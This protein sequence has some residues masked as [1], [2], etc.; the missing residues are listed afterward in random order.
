MVNISFN[1]A[2]KELKTAQ[3]AEVN[4]ISIFELL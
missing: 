3:I 1:N 4:H 2:C